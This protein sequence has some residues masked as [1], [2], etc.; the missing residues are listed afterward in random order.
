MAF[1]NKLTAGLDKVKQK[2]VVWLFMLLFVVATLCLPLFML[3][4]SFFCKAPY[5]NFA[6]YVF[7]FILLTLWAVWFFANYKRH[8]FSVFKKPFCLEKLMVWLL[9]AFLFWATLS[10]FFASDIT[11]ALFDGITGIRHEGLIM[12]FAYAGILLASTRLVD[13][14]R[15]LLMVLLF[16]STIIVL[17]AGLNDFAKLKCTYVVP[18]SAGWL[19][20]NHYGYFLAIASPASLGVF[21]LEDKPWLKWYAFGNFALINLAIFFND[22][23][24]VELSNF[25]VIIILLILLSKK[26]KGKRTEF[27][28]AV[29]VYLF[30][31]CADVLL[32][33]FGFQD[34]NFLQGL[35]GLVKDVFKIGKAPT[36]TETYVAGTNRWGLWLECLRNMRD[37]P[38]FG[39][40]INCQWLINPSLESGRP[41]NEFLQ[42]GSTMGVPSLLF[43]A[44]F[45]FSVLILGTKRIKKWDTY[46]TICFSAVIGY[47]ASSCF[48]VS[49][50]YTFSIYMVVLGLFVGSV[51]T[52]NT[53]AS[54]DV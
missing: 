18:F 31:L 48:G 42:F 53:K 2:G 9:L 37:K 54:V 25:V 3:V 20:P 5:Y 14:K 35:V 45:A 6:Y 10:V 16:S 1:D 23:L 4:V 50:P 36:S 21:L 44:G 38:L 7:G 12:Y 40:G 26:I 11:L 27:I 34:E 43:Y 19:N 32:S 13:E 28:L 24:G 49:L 30:A 29:G 41:H 8:D 22:T 17:L 52:K 51:T 47:L 33:K 15:F 46:T 39:I